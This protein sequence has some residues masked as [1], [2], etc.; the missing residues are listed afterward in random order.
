MSW[1]WRVELESGI[2]VGDRNHRPTRTGL[3]L[4]SPFCRV[5]RYITNTLI[6]KN[7]NNNSHVHHGVM[8]S[9]T[10]S[11][12]FADARNFTSAATLFSG[13][14]RRRAIDCILLC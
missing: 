10:G 12:S 4:R 5:N 13:K 2:G 3:R 11:G 7:A 8:V 9:T 6:V 1:S 14:S